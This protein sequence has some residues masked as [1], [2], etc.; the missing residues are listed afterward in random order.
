[1]ID[2]VVELADLLQRWFE[3]NASLLLLLVATWPAG[4]NLSRADVISANGNIR[5]GARRTCDA[6]GAMLPIDDAC[7]P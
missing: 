6:L 1:L 3:R 2:R 7:L 4:A 5:D